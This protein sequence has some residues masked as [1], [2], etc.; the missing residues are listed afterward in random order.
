[1]GP[2]GLLETLSDE[3]AALIERV[4][5]AVLHIRALRQGRPAVSGGSGVIVTPDGYA[6]TNHHVVA[7]ATAIEAALSDGRIL[8]SDVVGTDP[9]TDLAVLRLPSAGAFPFAPLGDSNLLRP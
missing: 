1:M 8:V 7:G 4:G 3:F 9:A 2:V 5:P 6:L